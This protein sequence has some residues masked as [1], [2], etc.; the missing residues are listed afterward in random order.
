MREVSSTSDIVLKLKNHY[1]KTIATYK[2]SAGQSCLLPLY[3]SKERLLDNNGKQVFIYTGE[4]EL[5]ISEC[6]TFYDFSKIK[7]KDLDYYLQH[8]KP[9]LQA[10]AK[11]QLKAFINLMESNLQLGRDKLTPPR[12]KELESGLLFY[13]EKKSDISFVF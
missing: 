4:G 6:Y 3:D 1:D 11:T 12:Y 8:Q 10:R 9:S 7:L 5:D 13:N 2:I